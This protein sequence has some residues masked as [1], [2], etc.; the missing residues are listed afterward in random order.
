MPSASAAELAKA[1]AALLGSLGLGEAPDRLV[2]T[3]IRAARLRPRDLSARSKAEKASDPFVRLSLTD[4]ASGGPSVQTAVRPNTNSAQWAGP[5]VLQ[6]PPGSVRYSRCSQFAAAEG[7]GAQAGRVGGLEGA[8]SSAPAAVLAR[9]A[10]GEDLPCWLLAGVRV[11]VIDDDEPATLGGPRAEQPLG[12]LGDLTFALWP[13]LADTGAAD[14]GALSAGTG[15]GSV[16]AAPVSELSRL[17]EG[18]ISEVEKGLSSLGFRWQLLRPGE[19]EPLA[20]TRAEEGE[21]PPGALAASAMSEGR[22]G[23]AAQQERGVADLGELEGALTV[24]V[25]VVAVEAEA[26]LMAAAA[27]VRLVCVRACVRA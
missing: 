7:T 10:A 6:L 19:P 5:L 24:V 15:V 26:E 8:L 16:S 3:H 20:H 21:L 4:R 13:Q 14:T 1:D 22:G 9:Q 2:L 11:A 25:A 23:A 27:K 17:L 18:S 12:A